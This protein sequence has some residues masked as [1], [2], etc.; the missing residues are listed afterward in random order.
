MTANPIDVVAEA[1]YGAVDGAISGVPWESALMTPGSI[2]RRR[3]EAG[4]AAVVSA[5]RDAGLL[6]TERPPLQPITDTVTLDDHRPAW[7]IGVASCS[8][9]EDDC[10]EADD[11]YPEGCVYCAGLDP[12]VDC[13]KSL[14]PAREDVW[15]TV[16]EYGALGVVLTVCE[17]Q[18][19]RADPSAVLTAA[20]VRLV[21]PAGGE[22]Q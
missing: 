6:V 21:S 9:A 15:R 2:R 3:Y 18:D 22:E 14:T 5:L 10:T 1:W 4:A 13:P 7:P 20:L 12:E 17:H 19:C 11:G 16:D 8:C